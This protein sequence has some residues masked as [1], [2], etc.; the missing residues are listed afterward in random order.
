MWFMKSSKRI[1]FVTRVENMASSDYKSK[2]DII[3][4]DTPT[5]TMHELIQSIVMIV[6]FLI[7][8]CI[9]YNEKG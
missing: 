8:D 5:K 6:I 3:I 7:G 4:Y 1:G 2:L 9:R